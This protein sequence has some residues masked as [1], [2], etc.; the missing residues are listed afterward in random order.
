MKKI[1]TIT[2]LIGAVISSLQVSAQKYAHVS[3]DSVLKSMPESDS[4]KKSYANYAGQLQSTFESFQKEYQQKLNDY[5]TNQA[6]YTGI[7]K[8]SKEQELQDLGQ[9]IQA[10][11]Q[12]AQTSLQH[13]G[14]SI[15]RPVIAK[16]KNAINAVAKEDGYKYVF[17]TSQ[18]F[19]L[20]ADD[21]DD[22]YMLVIKKLG[23][24]PKMASAPAA[25]K[26]K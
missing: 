8:Q 15:Q 11:Q 2:L 25:P 19:V 21:A 6:T 23:V 4:A 14:D 26:G 17:D 22:I 1:T 24:K 9:R 5:Q 10:F 12:Q 7:V 13:F 16:A 3:L 20:Y 18:G